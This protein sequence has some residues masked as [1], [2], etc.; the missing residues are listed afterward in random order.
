[1]EK[2]IKKRK[3]GTEVIEPFFERM[4]KLAQEERWS[5]SKLIQVSLERYLDL[6]K[7]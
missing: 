2:K 7:V 4:N 5:I 3:I 1:M 6:R